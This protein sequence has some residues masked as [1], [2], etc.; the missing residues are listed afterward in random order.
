MTGKTY[1]D[2]TPAVSYFYDQSTYNGLAITNGVGR[3]TGMSDGAGA[4]AWSF[5]SVAGVL[6]DRRTTNAVTRD[7]S[8]TYNL[9]GSLASILYPSGRRIDY[10]Y[11][12]AA[13]PLSAIDAASGINYATQAHYSP[14][15][16]LC[17]LRN[18]ASIT[19]TFTF[20]TR[21]QPNRI[22]VTTSGAP[23]TPCQ[24]PSQ[25]GNILD[26]T[27]GFNLGT[28]NNGNVAS[29]AN[30]RDTAR[31]QTFTYD[32]LNRVKTAETPAAWGLSFGYDIWA[33]LLSETVTK[34]SAPMLSIGVNNK[35]Q[36]SDAGF[37][38]DPGG[39]LTAQP[40]VTYQYD[41]EN[42]MSATAGVSYSYDGD[43]RR[44]KK[45]SGKLYWYGA[46]SE[47]LLETDL[48]G[49]SPDEYI[50][51]AGRRIARRKPAGEVNYY[52]ADHL[53]SSRVVTSATGQILDDSDFYP[54][55]GERPVLST[56][57]NNYKFTGKER[58]PESG[59]DYFG[60]RYDSS[61]LGRFMS[62]DAGPFHF[63]N[64]QSLNRYAYVL[65]NPL[66]YIDPDGAASISAVYRLGTASVTQFVPAGQSFDPTALLPSVSGFEPVPLGSLKQ[67]Q[68]NITFRPLDTGG[69][70]LFGCISTFNEVPVGLSLSLSFSYDEKKGQLT[71]ANIKIETDP[72]ARFIVSNPPAQRVAVIP[73][74]GMNPYPT[75][76]SSVNIDSSVL[77]KLS[78]EQ[79]QATLNAANSQVKPIR[80]AIRQAVLQEQRRRAEEQRKKEG[81]GQ[82]KK[83]QPAH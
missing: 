47:V 6:S 38:Y 68:P 75:E 73:L 34:G 56:S 53:G 3:R 18:G 54:F 80:D 58:D 72:N 14:A 62:P 59:L 83:F 49:N 46:G 71:G 21:L 11:N 82:R 44:V 40:G 1:S 27:Y 4:E 81:E 5:D 24:N 29:I 20:S 15:G 45:S 64:P 76:I 78:P 28:G 77:R 65:N 25:T 23:P 19:S 52:F 12:A 13:R 66:F 35:N 42:R 57:G 43:S 50:F 36:I 7:F 26:L 51:F 55:G 69:G 41:A 30:N 39:N 48:A 63:E 60:F 31:S 32:E 16:G 37:S 9:N 17:S 70:C 22:Q 2:T 67:D 79:L 61:S 8:Y 74:P 33:N 10:A